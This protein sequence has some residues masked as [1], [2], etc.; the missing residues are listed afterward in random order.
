[1]FIIIC[2]WNILPSISNYFVHHGLKIIYLSIENILYKHKLHTLIYMYCIRRMYKVYTYIW[3]IIM[4][5]IIATYLFSP[6]LGVQGGG[7]KVKIFFYK[8]REAFLQSSTY[9]A[10]PIYSKR[11]ITLFALQKFA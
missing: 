1:M 9:N 10:A 6:F 5:T 8:K 4:Y 11:V 7:K 3:Y 2:S